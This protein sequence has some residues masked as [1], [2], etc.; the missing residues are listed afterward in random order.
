MEAISA[1]ERY[2]KEKPKVTTMKPQMTPAVPPSVRIEA[3]VVR[4]TSHVATNVQPKPKMDRNW[5]FRY[6]SIISM[7]LPL[8]LDG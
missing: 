2:T 4:R 7:L 3:M 1:I 5:K 6:I 8:E